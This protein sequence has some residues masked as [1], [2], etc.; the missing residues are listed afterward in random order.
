MTSSWNAP[1][2]NCQKPSEITNKH[3]KVKL[4]IGTFLIL[5]LLLSGSLNAQKEHAGA[6]GMTRIL[7]VFDASQS[8]Y[9]R[10]ESGQK[11]DVA[12]R[13]LTKMLDSLQSLKSDKFEVALRVYGH[14]KPVRLRTAM[15]RALRL[16]LAL[17]ILP[18][19]SS[20]CEA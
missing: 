10:W 19:L 5:G 7:F 3:L 6:T 13:L 16:A 8:M 12:E 1:W 18:R 17:T 9:A 15:I 14:Q 2:H 20:A 4:H 11:V